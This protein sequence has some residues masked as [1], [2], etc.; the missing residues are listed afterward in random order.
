MLGKDTEWTKVFAGLKKLEKLNWNGFKQRLVTEFL[1][2]T[3]FWRI[4]ELSRIMFAIYIRQKKTQFFTLC[5][6]VN[7]FSPFGSCLKCVWKRKVLIVLDFQLIPHSF[8]SDMTEKQQKALTLFFCL[9]NSLCV[10][11]D[12]TNLSLHLKLL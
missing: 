4:W 8:F 1:W 3:Q 11:A 6:N 10:N 9:Q 5:A 7:T 12:W 2:Q